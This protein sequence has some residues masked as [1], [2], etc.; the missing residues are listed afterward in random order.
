MM[1]D[2][3]GVSKAGVRRATGVKRARWRGRRVYDRSVQ[4]ESGTMSVYGRTGQVGYGVG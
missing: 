2:D 3:E 1:D 4:S